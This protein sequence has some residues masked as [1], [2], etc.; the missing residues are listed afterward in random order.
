M[1]SIRLE[2]EIGVAPEAV[3]SAIRDVG[4]V[5][6]RFAR[7]FVVDCRLEE[8]SRIVTFANGAVVKE[9]IVDSDDKARRL[10]Y[11]V[12]GGSMTHHNASFQVFP[13]GAAATK[14]VW[15]VDLLPDTAADHMRMM[16]EQGSKAIR[17][18]LESAGAPP[19]K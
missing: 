13:A 15:I 8:G 17:M 5:H 3:W 6:T 19:H 2:I 10:A 12:S 1:A 9:L 14:L 18:T 11:A 7:G 16:M 4:A